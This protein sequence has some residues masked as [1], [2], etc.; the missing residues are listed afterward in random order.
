M[1]FQPSSVRFK[2]F[3]S[4]GNPRASGRLYTYAS[5]TTTHKAVYT[6][7]TLGTPQTYSTDGS[8]NKYITLDA[9]GECRAFLGSGAYTFTVTDSLGANSRNTD[10]ITD[11]EDAVDAL[12]AEI[13]GDGAAEG[14]GMLVFSPNVNYAVNTI[15]AR[16]VD[17]AVSIKAV[18]IGVS[19]GA[20]GGNVTDDTTAIQAAITYAASVKRAVYIP[21]DVSGYKIT[22]RLSVPY[23]VSIFGAGGEFSTIQCHSC[24]GIEFTSRSYDLGAFF[25]E[26]V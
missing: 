12:R 6:D 14:P 9:R 7:A 22:T 10:C 24:N 25:V 8:G 16:F 21:P 18:I 20:V 3:D 5:G 26:D 23:G 4:S 11:P 15:G 13:V 17:E 2:E 1:S 19:S